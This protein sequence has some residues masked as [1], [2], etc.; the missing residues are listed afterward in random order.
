MDGFGA[1][2]RST[3][4]PSYFRSEQGQESQI[5]IR[6]MVDFAIYYASMYFVA[7]KETILY[8]CLKLKNWDCSS[9]G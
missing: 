8:S 9:A 3:L 6:L 5:N 2:R 4:Y 7:N 1:V